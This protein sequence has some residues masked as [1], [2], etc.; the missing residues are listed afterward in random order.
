MTKLSVCMIVRDEEELLPQALESV[1]LLADQIVIVDTGSMDQTVAIAESF[2]AEV[3]HH[4]WS[5]N[6][7]YHR[8]Q[9][10]GYA[11]GDYVI[12]LDADEKICIDPNLTKEDIN[13]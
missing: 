6:F 12:I 1:K 8:N 2:G 10:I 3:Y 11:T 9:S 7:S 4:P 13:E 5:N